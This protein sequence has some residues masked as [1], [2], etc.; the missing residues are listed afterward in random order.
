VLV[1]EVL[2][3]AYQVNLDLSWMHAEI[4]SGQSIQVS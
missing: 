2:V 4:E 3:A 1:V